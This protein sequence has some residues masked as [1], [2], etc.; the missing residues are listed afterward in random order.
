MEEDIKDA[1]LAVQAKDERRVAV[2]VVV[3]N[4][5]QIQD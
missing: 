1:R 4:H 5:S 2:E 3:V